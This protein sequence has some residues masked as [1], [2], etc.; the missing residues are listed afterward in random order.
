MPVQGS[1]VELS[2]EIN[3]AKP[4]IDTVG[5]RNVHQPVFA[6]QWH[7]GFGAL[8]GKRKEAGALT[9]THNYGKNI[10]G[11]RGLAARFC[12]NKSSVRCSASP[13]LIR[14]SPRLQARTPG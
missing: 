4:G 13:L 2:Q 5:N 9:P 7:G 10:A 14:R 8:L 1:R 6:G 12:H 3:A 11:V